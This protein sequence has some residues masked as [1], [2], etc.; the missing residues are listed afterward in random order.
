MC[1]RLLALDEIQLRPTSPTTVAVD[2][3]GRRSLQAQAFP[4]EFG[5]NVVV[6]SGLRQESLRQEMHLDDIHNQRKVSLLPTNGTESMKGL[7]SLQIV[8]CTQLTDSTLNALM[9][10]PSLVEL[11]ISGCPI[12]SDSQVCSVRKHGVIVKATA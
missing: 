7:Q 2:A 8:W 11:D 10:I 9:L 6:T 3:V 12:I 5:S 1:P 4:Q